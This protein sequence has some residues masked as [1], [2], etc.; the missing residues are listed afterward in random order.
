MNISYDELKALAREKRQQYGVATRKLG[1]TKVRE[2]YRGEGVT[3]DYMKMSSKIRAI[4][5]C[6]DGD[7][8]VAVNKQLPNVPKLF[9]LV[10]ELKHHFVDREEIERGGMKCGD[11]NANR[12]IEIGAEIFAAEFIY[13]EAEFLEDATN[14]GLKPMALVAE[15]I[16]RFRKSCEATISYRFLLKRLERF[17]FISEGQFS[18]VQFQKLEEEVFGVPIYKQDWF[19]AQRARRALWSGRN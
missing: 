18:N 17:G 2:I 3:I 16:V 9:S 10:H 19:K 7:P 11:Y 8:S 1:L 6:D 12:R 15:D 14:Y 4:Y 5:M 13:P